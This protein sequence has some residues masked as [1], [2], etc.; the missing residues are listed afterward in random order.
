[1]SVSHLVGGGEAIVTVGVSAEEPLASARFINDRSSWKPGVNE[2]E[3]AAARGHVINLD[4]DTCIQRG[5]TE[6]HSVV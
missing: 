3:M 4:T 6:A 5:L 2:T 1:M